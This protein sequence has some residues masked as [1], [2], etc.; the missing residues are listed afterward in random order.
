MTFLRTVCGMGSAGGVAAVSEEA[1]RA[2]A[3][4]RTASYGSLRPTRCEL[5]QGHDGQ[6]EARF[7]KRIWRWTSQ[8]YGLSVRFD[9]NDENPAQPEEG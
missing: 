1:C 2:L 8:P 6:H 5:A 9:V 4:F 7:A 3:H